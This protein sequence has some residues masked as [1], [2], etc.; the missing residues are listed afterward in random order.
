[1]QNARRY[2]MGCFVG[3]DI[4]KSKHDYAIVDDSGGILKTGELSSY[5]GSDQAKHLIII[6]FHQNKPYFQSLGLPFYRANEHCKHFQ[7]LSRCKYHHPNWLSA[8]TH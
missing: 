6:T 5:T 3:I 4:G 1:M 2:I 8:P 7:A